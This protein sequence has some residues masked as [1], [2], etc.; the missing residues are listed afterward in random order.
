MGNEGGKITSYDD[1]CIDGLAGG[2][3][4]GVVSLD[5]GLRGLKARRTTSLVFGRRARVAAA[6]EDD[7]C[8]S[9]DSGGFRTEWSDA[10]AAAGGGRVK[11]LRRR[12]QGEALSARRPSVAM[13]NRRHLL[14]ESSS[15]PSSPGHSPHTQDR[16]TVSAKGSPVGAASP[17][18]VSGL[19]D[20]PQEARS[21]S[22]S[23]P[24]PPP[25]SSSFR[26]FSARVPTT[27]TNTT[28]T[29][30]SPAAVSAST[31]TATTTVQA[32]VHRNVLARAALP[33]GA[34]DE[35]LGGTGGGPV[36]PPPTAGG[37]FPRTGTLS[38]TPRLTRGLA[39]TASP[40]PTNIDTCRTSPRD[41][42]GAPPPPPEPAPSFSAA[43]AT[44]T[45]RPQFRK[46]SAIASL[47][48]HGGHLGRRAPPL[49]AGWSA[50]RVLLTGN[51]RRLAQGFE[52]KAS[53]GADAPDSS[54]DDRWLPTSVRL[55]RLLRHTQAR[56]AATTIAH[57]R[58][59]PP[60]PRHDS[61]VLHRHA[62]ACRGPS[63]FPA[64][65]PAESPPPCDC[66]A[67]P[68]SP[69]PTHLSSNRHS[70]SPI[71]GSSIH[72]YI[73]YTAALTYTHLE[74]V[75]APPPRRITRHTA[76]HTPPRPAT[77]THC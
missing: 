63:A 64:T 67:P 18:P 9:D 52:E 75:L 62:Q 21:A 66:A 25:R 1:L 40:P 7:T 31:A 24:S 51:V 17:T 35:G 12:R 50:R 49:P 20:Q 26:E 39:T 6:T 16:G 46:S 32:E 68:Q 71:P 13:V 15:P 22:K 58:P 65:H 77:P 28:T 10:E 54:G 69:F 14:A 73:T 47:Y 61:K 48:L 70:H 33:G 29:A 4:S 37:A 44:A 76:R 3:G 8:S 34:E 36:K 38:F 43:T 41:D 30:V 53:S 74:G 55:R 59:P 19:T 57:R 45:A 56:A 27:I 23:P 72:A 5:S 11:V 42:S 60:P 2:G